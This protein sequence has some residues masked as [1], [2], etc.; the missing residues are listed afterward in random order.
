MHL[1]GS[2]AGYPATLAE[3]PPLAVRLYTV[4]DLEGLVDRDALLRGDAEPPYWAYLWAGSRCLAAYV[5]RWVDVRRRRVL[6]IGCGLGLTGLVAA[7]RG[8]HV[9]FVDGALPA[10]AFVRASL[11]AN[12]L[13]AVAVCADFHSLAPTAR[14]D[15]ILAAEIAY[16]PATFDTLAATLARHLAPGGTAYLA[17]GFRTDTRALYRALDARGLATRA[18]D[19]RPLEEGRPTR[20]RLTQAT[21][22]RRT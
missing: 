21:P 4:P 2:I 8:A 17:D 9:V 12:D 20:V 14:F 11:A 1:D 13:D 18:L 15:C 6:D 5:E 19:L 3:V 7:R 22:R 16:E 10:L